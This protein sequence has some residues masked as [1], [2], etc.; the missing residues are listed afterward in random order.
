MAS[1]MFFVD[2]SAEAENRWGSPLGGCFQVAGI[3]CRRH[4]TRYLS[5]ILSR[6]FAS[7]SAN[8]LAGIHRCDLDQICKRC[9]PS[10]LSR[11]L[12]RCRRKHSASSSRLRLHDLFPLSKL[13]GNRLPDDVGDLLTGDLAT[14]NKRKSMI[15][16]A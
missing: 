16:S 12:H 5:L 7:V 15:Y 1:W 13:S 6:R 2:H 8:T 11:R 3:K 4:A 9:I 10:L 14:N